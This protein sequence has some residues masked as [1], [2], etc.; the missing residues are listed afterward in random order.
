MKSGG[1]CRWSGHQPHQLSDLIATHQITAERD[2][3]IL[4]GILQCAREAEPG[5]GFKG[6][7]AHG[8]CRRPDG[9]THDNAQCT[10]VLQDN[11]RGQPCRVVSKWANIVWNLIPTDW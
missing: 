8:P 5:L 11:Q 2:D 9:I 6:R 7:R 10:P 3:G 4:I 1:F